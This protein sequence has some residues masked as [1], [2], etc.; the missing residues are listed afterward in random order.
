MGIEEVRRGRGRKGSE[1]GG[2]GRE[3]K[4]NLELF[5]LGRYREVVLWESFWIFI[6]GDICI[7]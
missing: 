2:K 3:G 7:L 4:N 6:A 1:G 5:G